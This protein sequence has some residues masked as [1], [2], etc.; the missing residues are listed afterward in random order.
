MENPYNNETILMEKPY[1][2][3]L[4]E[5]PYNNETILTGCV[6]HWGYGDLQP[7]GNVWF[8]E[9]FQIAAVLSSKMLHWAEYN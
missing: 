8:S 1:E 7:A 4:M 9:V 5:Q 2:T 6:I 3:I